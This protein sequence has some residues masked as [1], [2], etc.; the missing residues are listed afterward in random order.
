[1]KLSKITVAA[2]QTPIRHDAA[3]S[4]I[5]RPQF[6]HS[7]RGLLSLRAVG[8]ALFRAVD[9]VE[10]DTFSAVGVQDFDGVAVEDGGG[11]S[12]PVI[13][14]LFLMSFNDW[15]IQFVNYPVRLWKTDALIVRY[16]R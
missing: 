4:R 9:A 15:F 12:G 6:S 3:C 1:M 13:A 10:A 8:L 2:G 14:G 5:I 16:P 11:S 7:G